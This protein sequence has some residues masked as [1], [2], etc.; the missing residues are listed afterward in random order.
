LL[1]L[2]LEK[3]RLMKT[4][5]LGKEEKLLKSIEFKGALSRGSGSRTEHFT[6]LICPNNLMQRRMGITAS[7]KVG[8]AA[9]RNRVKRLLREFFRLNKLWLPPSSDI[10]FIAKPGA[11]KLDYAGLR[12]ELTG[13][14]LRQP[15]RVRNGQ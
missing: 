4:Y 10:V 6:I 14:F 13:V 9:Q 7:R 8:S 3:L 2:A 5:G 12:E 15:P 11:D 1:P